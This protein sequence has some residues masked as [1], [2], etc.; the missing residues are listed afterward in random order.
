MGD[1]TGSGTFHRSEPQLGV[2]RVLFESDAGA[3]GADT[4]KI[5]LGSY[6]ITKLLGINE[7]IHTGTAF[8]GNIIPSSAYQGDLAENV[9]TDVASGVLTL[10]FGTGSDTKH[11]VEIIGR[12]GL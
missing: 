9:T 7:W 4:V 11:V 10:N 2:T 3:D 6:G 12:P 8:T 5:T 1:V